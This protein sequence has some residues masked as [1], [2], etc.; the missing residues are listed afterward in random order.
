MKNYQIILT[1]LAGNQHHEPYDKK[2]RPTL[3]NL[4]K[5]WDIRPP[6]R[7]YSTEKDEMTNELSDEFLKRNLRTWRTNGFDNSCC[8]I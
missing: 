4:K 2:R 3:Q 7:L 8:I 6:N 5:K 1:D